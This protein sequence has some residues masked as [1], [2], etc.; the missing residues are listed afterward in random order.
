MKNL[1]W[2]IVE[3]NYQ[4]KI[5]IPKAIR[6]AADESGIDLSDNVAIRLTNLKTGEEY[7]SR[8]NITGT[9]FYVPVEAQKMLEGAQRIRLKIY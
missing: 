1:E 5:N 9:E 8:L 7:L 6:A 4:E 2:E 3:D